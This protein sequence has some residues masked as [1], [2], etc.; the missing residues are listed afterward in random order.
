[1][2]GL[3]IRNINR[4]KKAIRTLIRNVFILLL[5]PLVAMQITD[6]V[7]WT[8]TDFIIAFIL[9]T[10]GG[11]SITWINA[12]VKTPHYKIIL[13]VLLLLIFFLV[14]AELAVRLFGTVFA[15]I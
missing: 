10:S 1:M 6:Q 15:G 3:D 5:I 11:L 13:M 2:E 8:P 7:Q 4:M 14:W 12:K 9:F